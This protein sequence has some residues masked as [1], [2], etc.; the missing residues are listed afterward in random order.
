MNRRVIAY[1]SPDLVFQPENIR[2]AFASHA[3]FM[4]GVMVIDECCP[5]DEHMEHRH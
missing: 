2:A 1:G 5:G 4:E 3:L